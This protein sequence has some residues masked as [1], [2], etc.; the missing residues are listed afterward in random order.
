[1]RCGACEAWLIAKR[2]SLRFC[3]RSDR[4]CVA[5]RCRPRSGDVFWNGL[6]RPVIPVMTSDARLATFAISCELAKSSNR[7]YLCLTATHESTPVPWTVGQC[8]RFSVNVFSKKRPSLFPGRLL[9][10]SGR[11]ID[12]IACLLLVRFG[13]ST[14]HRLINQIGNRF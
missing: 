3:S 14:S 1:M 4:N 2:R 13:R 10:D 6:T 8:G 7:P 12:L 5:L 9:N 11:L